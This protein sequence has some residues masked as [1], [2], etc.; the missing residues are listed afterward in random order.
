MKTIDWC[1][2]VPV[3]VAVFAVPAETA[4]Y[5]QKINA[6]HPAAVAKG[7][8]AIVVQVETPSRSAD[9]KWS[10]K[11]YAPNIKDPQFKSV[12]I[13]VDAAAQVS[14]HS[15]TVAQL[16]FGSRRSIARGIDTA[17]IFHAGSWLGRLSRWDLDPEHVSELFPGSVV[18]HSH[19]AKPPISGKLLRRAD[20][21]ALSNN[22]LH[23]AGVRRGG[24]GDPIM[25]GGYNS[26][27]VGGAMKNIETPYPV[28]DELYGEGRTRPHVVGPYPN[29]SAAA[30]IAA[31]AAVRLNALAADKAL[32]FPT[33]S[34]HG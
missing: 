22:V 12:D 14:S 16:F 27:V 25:A 33:T 17:Y 2:V 30:P 5:Q 9:G 26:L 4:A 20:Y 7:T 10:S 29:A 8:N 32:V 1:A 15:N 11:H 18:N 23:V 19:V 21:S 24:P 31:A 28:I 34:R 13:R 6:T 3:L